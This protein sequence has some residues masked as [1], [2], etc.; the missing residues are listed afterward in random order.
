VKKGVV[1]GMAADDVKVPYVA[2]ED[3]GEFARLAFEDPDTFLGRKL[4][5]IGDFISGD[6]LAELARR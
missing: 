5:L 3:I 4:N 1:T 2:C 6:D